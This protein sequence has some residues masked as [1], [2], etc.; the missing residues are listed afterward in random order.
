[1]EFSVLGALA[2]SD[3][4]RGVELRGVLRRRLLAALL[5]QAN[6]V[7][8]ADFLIDVLW[9]D[10]VPAKAVRNLHN[11]M[12]RVRAALACSADVTIVTQP[13]GYLLQV[14][15]E[16]IDAIRFER[17][18]AEVTGLLVSDPASAE[19][20]LVEAL[21]LWRGS[22]FAEFDGEEFCRYEV[23]RLEELRLVAM[24]ARFTAGLAMGRHIEL[25]AELEAFAAEHALR[26]L[27]RGLLMTALYRSSRQAD[28]LAVYQNFRH[29]LSDE[30]GIEPSEALSMRHQHILTGDVAELEPVIMAQPSPDLPD[31]RRSHK[32]GNLRVERSELVGRTADVALALGMLTRHRIVT[33]TGVGGVGKT[34]L[35]L[36]VAA[37]VQDRFQHG[38]WVCE[39]SAVRD[40]ELVPDRVAMTLRV[41]ELRG[42]A[43]TDG[44]VEFLGSRR[45]LLMI[46][47][48]EHV[49]NG[50][51]RLVD[52]LVS[53]CPDITVLATS[54]EP[55]GVDG[56]YV[57]PVRP[58]ALP[59]LE[60]TEELS[61]VVAV[62]AVALF[63]ERATAA[64]PGFTLAPNNVAAV[65]EICRRLDGL[66]LA[67][68]LAAARVR[69]MSVGDIA[70]RLERRLHFLHSTSRAR[71]ERHTS[72]GALVGWSYELL[73][74]SER[75]VFDRLSVL[76][77]SFTLDDAVAI[78]RS[79]AVG[80]DEVV[81]AVT[82]LVHKSMLAADTG[83]VATRFTMLETLRL[84]GRE[85]LQRNGQLPKVLRRHTEY[86]VSVGERQGPA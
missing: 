61:Q 22:A 60:G 9:G 15:P 67:I 65:S 82:G 13:P 71:E 70:A 59:A 79:P 39:L 51:V 23:V 85:R 72:L 86:R 18:V 57:L 27:P 14:E 4:G 69:S 75:F 20:Q 44:L 28:A 77:D 46:D 63:V 8:S 37:G 55:L 73:E 81:N 43:S 56:E 19:S 42:F 33:M 45:V 78:A 66:P 49:L 6:T 21:A 84:Y 34:R 54:R 47:N 83:G 38:V 32:V 11:Q 68:E 74:P 30:L 76:A 25:V 48:C 29:Q 52:T 35:A 7:V 5:V 26:E 31:G 62:P 64:T 58:L 3:A 24:E 10:R 12:W 53:N 50:A 36:R 80:P 16:A 41:R 1:M 40:G 2:V 17:M